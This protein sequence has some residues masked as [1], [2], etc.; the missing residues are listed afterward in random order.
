MLQRHRG[1]RTMCGCYR[2]ILFINCSLP[3]LIQNFCHI[4]FQIVWK[5]GEPSKVNYFLSS[6]FLCLL[7]STARTLQSSLIMVE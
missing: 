5:G 2:K 3:L 7:P 4:L 6:V 1:W